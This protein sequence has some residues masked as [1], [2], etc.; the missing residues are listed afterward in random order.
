MADA[1]QRSAEHILPVRPQPPGV[2]GNVLGV[3]DNQDRSTVVAGSTGALDAIVVA[4]CGHF[5]C[6]RR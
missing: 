4:H 6:P 1:G 3:G 2:I 5:E